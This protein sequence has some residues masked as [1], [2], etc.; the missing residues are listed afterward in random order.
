MASKV[1]TVAGTDTPKGYQQ[2][3]TVS[4]SVGLTVPD[5]CRWALIRAETQNVRW[6]DDGTPPTATV[7]TEL[8]VGEALGYTGN[9][10]A[11]LF[12]EET[13]SAKLSITYYG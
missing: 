9:L 10:K 12:I 13:A 11:I 2:I 7:G 6:R 1:E 3:T 4:A 5:G 8:L